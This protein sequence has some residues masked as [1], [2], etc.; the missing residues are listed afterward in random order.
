MDKLKLIKNLRKM[1]R[2]KGFTF[3]KVREGRHEIWAIGSQKIQIPRHNEISGRNS[4][5][6]HERGAAS[7]ARTRGRT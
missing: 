2:D 7:E 4:C 5:Q 6:D 1:A 3:V